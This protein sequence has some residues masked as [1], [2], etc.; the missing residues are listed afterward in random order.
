VRPRGAVCL[1]AA[2]TAAVAAAVLFSL[3][4]LAFPLTLAF[5][6][7]AGFFAFRGQVSRRACRAVSA[8]R[9]D[10]DGAF[11]LRTRNGW[12]PAEWLGSWRGPRWLTL[13]AR[14]PAGVCNGAAVA[15]RHVTVTVWQDA[16]PTP[17]WRRACLLVN[18]RLCRTPSARAAGVT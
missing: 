16:L 12:Q 10:R 13:R 4:G 11:H 7:A 18:R 5:I 8:I 2:V 17:A 9:M 15:G 6:V 3:H 14:L 1:D